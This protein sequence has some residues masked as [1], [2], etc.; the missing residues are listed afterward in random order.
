[1]RAALRQAGAVAFAENNPD[2]TDLH[3]FDLHG[4][5][6]N[7]ALDTVDAA[8]DDHDASCGSDGGCTV[9]FITGVGQHSKG[10]RARLRPALRRHLQDIGSS[11]SVRLAWAYVGARV[12]VCGCVPV[13]VCGV[14]AVALCACVRVRACV[15]LVFTLP[16]KGG[17]GPFMLAECPT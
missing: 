16:R 7:D 17:G 13:R 2:A 5:I 10:G 8:L 12:R 9:V 6:V 14:Y 1:M 3:R 11:F 15:G 4:L